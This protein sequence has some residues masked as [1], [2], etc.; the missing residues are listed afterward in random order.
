MLVPTISRY[1]ALV[2]VL[3]GL[4]PAAARAQSP[5][6]D[7]L[8]TDPPPISAPPQPLRFGITP[9]L[10]GSVGAAQVEPKPEDPA[11]AQA[12][13]DALRPAGSQLV[14]RLNRMFW[15]DGAEGLRRYKGIVDRYAA[16]GFDTELQVRY[17]PPEGMAGNMPA[18]KRY[19]KRAAGV[20][21]RRES[22]VALSITNEAN[23]A[24]S[25]N[26]SDGSY[27]GVREAVVK[28]ISIADRKLRR[29]GRTDI[30]LGFSF[31]WRW[32]PGSDRSFWEEIGA[33]ATPRFRRG[34]DYVGLQIYPGLVIPPVLLPGRSAGDEVIEALTLLRSCYMPKAGLGPDTNLWVS[35]NG[36]ATNLGRS[37]ASQADALASTLESLR[38]YSGTLGVSDYRY[39]NLRDNNSLGPD[40]FDGVGLLR[41]GY[42]RKP[43]FEVLRDAIATI[44]VR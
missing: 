35:E 24:V 27:A 22:V 41:D 28:G 26:T 30:E 6:A 42:S 33:L 43:G 39:F 36:Y 13:L 37:E 15:A 21:G 10:A 25:P 7:C 1:F 4:L 29:M 14:L 2:A 19:V 9:L 5:D 11:Q 20:F 40:L 3:A 16:A 8:S 23:F 44:G 12:A 32:F 18:W 34:L 31:A 17:H 38:A